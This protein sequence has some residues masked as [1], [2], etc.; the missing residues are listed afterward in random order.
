MNVCEIDP[1][2][3][4]NTSEKIVSKNKTNEEKQSKDFRLILKDKIK[5]YVRRNRR[6]TRVK[7]ISDKGKTKSICYVESKNY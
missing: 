7:F 2:Y 4:L 5:K 3:M 6:K 1:K